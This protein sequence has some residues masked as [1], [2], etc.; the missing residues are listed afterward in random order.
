MTPTIPQKA[1][2]AVIEAFGPELTLKSDRPVVQLSALAPGEC[3]INRLRRM[4]SLHKHAPFIALFSLLSVTFV[5]LSVAEFN[6]LER[7]V[8][9]LPPFRSSIQSYIRL[10][11]TLTSLWFIFILSSVVMLMRLSSA[12]TAGGYTGV[13]TAFIAYYI[14]LSDLAAAEGSPLE[15]LFERIENLA[16]LLN[17][18][19]GICGET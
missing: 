19:P 10:Y 18:F 1:R 14:G 4:V 16:G 5:L 9:M 2:A 15:R 7:S 17:V 3:L 6:Q 13:I 12:N 11:L 8:S